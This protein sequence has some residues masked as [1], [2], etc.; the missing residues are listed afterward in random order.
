M[1]R[2]VESAL[3]RDHVAAA[4]G[5]LAQLDGGVDGVRAGRT[6][7]VHLHAVGHPA[8]QHRQLGLG[9]GVLGR[10]R[11]VQPVHEAT[12]L[13]G[14]RSD[15]LGVVV[16]QR[17]DPRPGEEVDEDVAVDVTQEAALG[18]VDGDREV[19]TVDAGVRLAPL[20]AGEQG[21]RAGT[22][23]LAADG[24]ARGGAEIVEQGHAVPPL[25]FS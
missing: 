12:Q 23:Q 24:R 13:L 9:E 4:R 14:R 17:Q 25:A 20:L 16:A 7:E 8:G 22:R 5:G 3:E 2:A 10:R 1:G 18:L 21:R 15:Q 19:P 6:A 11:Q